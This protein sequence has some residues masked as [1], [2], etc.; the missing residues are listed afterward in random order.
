[1]MARHDPCY[2]DDDVD[3]HPAER[4]CNALIRVIFFDIDGTLLSN[5]TH[6]VSTSVRNALAAL[7][8]QGIQIVA[9]TG[10]HWL[11]LRD[12]PVSTIPF[13]AYLTLNGQLW[14]DHDHNCRYRSPLPQP[15]QKQLRD[16]FDSRRLPILLIEEK[17]MV[18][19]YINDAVKQ[20]QTAIQTALPDIGTDSSSPLYQAIAFAPS[21]DRTW[22]QPLL[23]HCRITSWHRYAMDIISDTGG[24]C[25]SILR[26]L[27][28]QQISLEET[29]A[30]GDGENDIEMLQLAHIGIAMGNA[31]EAVKQAAD[32]VTAS[33]DED[34]VVLAL[35][36]L[37]QQGY[38]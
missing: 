14:L 12:L 32:F 2:N 18:I 24:K 9:A 28:Q 26:Y 33:V 30:F 19:N 8:K 6:T 36:T 21:A 11:E 1:M 10:R 38:L 5:R 17:R 37:H 16:L 25:S 31:D 29:A 22:L 7:Q 35:H 4:K 23:P 27:Q 15:D 20:A 3:L 34:G 13:D